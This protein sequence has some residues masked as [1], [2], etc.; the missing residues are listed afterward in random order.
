MPEN[1]LHIAC[2]RK[3][4]PEAQRLVDRTPGGG[5]G[6]DEA[7]AALCREKDKYGRLPLH[8]ALLP[9]LQYLTRQFD[10][11]GPCP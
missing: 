6:A 7:A 4:W 10:R 9:R 8:W 2:R 11:Q 1:A 5:A 3:D